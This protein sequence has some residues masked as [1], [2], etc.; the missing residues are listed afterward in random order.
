MLGGGNIV[1]GLM[2]WKQAIIRQNHILEMQRHLED[3]FVKMAEIVTL[4]PCM[5]F[6]DRG[7]VDGKAY[8]TDD[9]WQAIMSRMKTTKF[10]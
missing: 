6:C 8:V 5:I 4:K 9:L 10:N 7:L 2:P 1:V 3:Y